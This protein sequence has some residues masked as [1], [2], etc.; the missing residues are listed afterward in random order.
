MKIEIRF[1]PETDAERGG[2]GEAVSVEM[3]AATVFAGY[4]RT[5]PY[6]FLLEADLHGGLP[7]WSDPGVIAVS[8]EDDAT[9]EAFSASYAAAG[10]DG[11]IPASF[12]AGLPVRPFKASSRN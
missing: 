10:P 2:L 6:L 1:I 5:S 7:K 9:A 12:T 4:R 11:E 3:T 8:C